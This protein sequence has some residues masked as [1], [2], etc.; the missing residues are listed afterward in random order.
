MLICRT[1][2]IMVEL[3]SILFGN[4][5]QHMVGGHPSVRELLRLM[6]MSWLRS[7]TWEVGRCQRSSNMLARKETH[8]RIPKVNDFLPFK[9]LLFAGF[10]TLPFCY[11]ARKHKSP[12]QNDQNSILTRKG[13]CDWNQLNSTAFNF[14]CN[15]CKLA[16][17][18]N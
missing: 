12:F 2:P 11:S 14:F 5:W 7:S 6:M 4:H 15:F 13:H 3:A 10:S 9:W 17:L 16:I 8:Q 1:R 18:K